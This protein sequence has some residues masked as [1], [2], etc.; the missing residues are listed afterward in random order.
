MN[1]KL[2]QIVKYS[3]ENVPFYAKNIIY[4]DIDNF[5]QFDIIKKDDILTNRMDFLSMEH[6]KYYHEGRIKIKYTSGSTGEATIVFW[7]EVDDALADLS[8]WKYRK[9]WY[10]ISPFNRYLSFFSNIYFGNQIEEKSENIYLKSNHLLCNKKMINEFEIFEFVKAFF[11]FQPEWILIQPSIF[12]LCSHLI[13]KETFDKMLHT[14]KYIEFTGEYISFDYI[15]HLKKI[16]PHINFANMYGT[17]ET[18][19]IAITCPYG[20][21]HIL[22]NNIYVEILD[23]F[24]VPSNGEVGSVILTSLKNTAMP[25]I[26]YQIGDRA[27]FLDIKCPCGCDLQ[28]IELLAGRECDYIYCDG[29]KKPVYLLSSAVEKVN[30]EFNY[31]IYKVNFIQKKENLIEGNLFLKPEFENWKES[32]STSLREELSREIGSNIEI[33]FIFSKI[34]KNNKKD[35]FFVNLLADKE[36]I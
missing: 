18:G 26:R 5:F 12:L 15:E 35:P 14:V 30:Y 6:K 21:M 11:D 10:N 24:G 23:K 13:N 7:D 20:H 29:N 1:N 28:V 17:T 22:Q 32:I 3:Y 34:P 36:K 27:K 9:L 16:Y 31:P 2:S 8:A 4:K 25:L 19:V 33:T